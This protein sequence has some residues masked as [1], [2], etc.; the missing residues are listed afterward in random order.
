[1]TNCVVII[2]LLSLYKENKEIAL[3][4]D[5]KNVA[6]ILTPSDRNITK[7]DNVFDLMKKVRSE[8]FRTVKIKMELSGCSLLES[9]ISELDI[10]ALKLKQ[11]ITQKFSVKNTL[12]TKEKR[13]VPPVSMTQY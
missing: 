12:I 13:V 9:D 3:R 8:V 5:T 4:F 11:I 2:D 7:H 10:F 6:G 1:M